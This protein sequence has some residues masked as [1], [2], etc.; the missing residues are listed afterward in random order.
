MTHLDEDILIALAVG[1]SQERDE[2]DHLSRC[3]GCTHQLA[4][5]RRTTAAVRAGADRALVPPPDSVWAAIQTELSDDL[6]EHGDTRQ[7]SD[8]AKHRAKTRQSSGA[9]GPPTRRPAATWLAVAAT[10]GILVGAGATWVARPASEAPVQPDPVTQVAAAELGPLE[11]DGLTGQATVVETAREIDLRVQAEPVDPADGYL[12]VWLINEDGVR[13]VSVGVL[14]ADAER[15]SFP[16]SR[17]LIDQG[18]V[19][20]DISREAF[21]DAP[22]HSGD[23]VLRGQLDRA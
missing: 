23:S 22:E 15:H 20:V 19:I 13:M 9:A 7:I 16:I 10:V 6:D 3:V 5:L 18:Y 14:P 8:I 4:S 11:G 21:D 12:E 2:T 1:E 17:D